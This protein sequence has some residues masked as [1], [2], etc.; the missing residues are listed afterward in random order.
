MGVP[1]ERARTMT[2]YSTDVQ[3]DHK[4]KGECKG[5]LIADENSLR[6]ES[7]TEANHSR[8]WNY[9]DVQSFDKE[10]DHSLLKVTSKN[11]GEAE[12]FR[13]VNGKTAGALYELVAQKIVSA[14]P[15]SQ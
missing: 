7:V 15:A 12:Q 13:T 6:F 9:N 4:G 1:Q 14:R 2:T 3:H 10:K 8:T 11:V 5:K